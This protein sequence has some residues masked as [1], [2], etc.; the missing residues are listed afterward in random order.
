M[1]HAS[2]IL[3]LLCVTALG[4]PAITVYRRWPDFIFAYV[5][6]A[7]TAFVLF[8]WCLSRKSKDAD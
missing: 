3:D 5:G 6:L 4:L 7:L 2:A 8:A 1:K